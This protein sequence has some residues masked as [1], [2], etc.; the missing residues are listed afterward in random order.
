MKALHC[1]RLVIDC[2]HFAPERRGQVATAIVQSMTP[3]SSANFA[4]K[5]HTGASTEKSPPQGLCLVKLFENTFG[6]HQGTDP[7]G[8]PFLEIPDMFRLSF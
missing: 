3:R 4:C 1:N 6:V 8:R 2:G 7:A 5:N